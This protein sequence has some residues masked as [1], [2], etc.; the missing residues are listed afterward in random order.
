MKIRLF[1]ILIVSIQ[2]LSGCK[3]PQFF[4]QESNFTNYKQGSI[5]ESIK[6]GDKIVVLSKDSYLY[7]GRLVYIKHDILR[8][9]EKQ[10]TV[11]E[12]PLTEVEHIKTY[13]FAPLKTVGL[14]LA[15]GIS[16]IPIIGANQCC[17]R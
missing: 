14:V 6:T 10:G 5:Y 9:Q 2:L 3:S 7:E 17:G 4:S 11:F 15:I 12:I 16:F 8:G 13:R 1:S